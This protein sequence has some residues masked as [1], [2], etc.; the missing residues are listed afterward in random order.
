MLTRLTGKGKKKS[1][2]NSPQEPPKKKRSKMS[3]S[4]G[5]SS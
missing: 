5:Q 1:D 2:N 4:K 3:A